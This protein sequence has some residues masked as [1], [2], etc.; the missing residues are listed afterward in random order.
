MS[1]HRG[2]P[3][4]SISDVIASDPMFAHDEKGKTIVRERSCEC[5]KRFT[6][7]LLSARFLAI[8]E[9]QGIGALRALQRG[10]PDFY[11]PVHCPP[12]ERR[13]LGFAAR[14]VGYGAPEAA[15]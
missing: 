2:G 13:D 7:R 15:D 10:V 3:A 12:C 4:Q 8:A 1:D 6:Q 5:G 11:V 14:R 9:R